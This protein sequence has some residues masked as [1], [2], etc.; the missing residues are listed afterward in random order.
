MPM[1]TRA[2]TTARTRAALLRAATRLLDTGGAEAV[3]LRAVGE[4]AKVSH[5]AA[6]RHF[7]GKE[8]M[9]AAISTAGWEAIVDELEAIADDSSRTP[10]AALR[11]GVGA[12]LALARTRPERYR[13]MLTLAP[14]GDGA[15]ELGD[16][17]MTVF[18][19]LVG[20]VV[21]EAVARPAAGL[22]LAAAHGIADL[23]V[24][25]IISRE[26]YDTDAEGLADLLVAS[27]ARTR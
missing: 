21:D 7:T 6:Y 12:L 19:R 14:F 10:E 9:L 22:I 26:K 3:T 25:G 24:R 8:A 4:R 11:D 17:A 13:L 5:S 15:S 2:E 23:D 20:G 27:V 18:G 1:P 16:R